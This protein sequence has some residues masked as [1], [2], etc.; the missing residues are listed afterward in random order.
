MPKI[1]LAAARWDTLLAQLRAIA[2]EMFDSQNSSL[3]NHIAGAWKLSGK[4]R[5]VVSPVDGTVLGQLPMLNAEEGKQAVRAAAAEFSA[6]RS[7]PLEERRQAVSQTVDAFQKHRDLFAYLLAWE[8]G[9]PV[10]QSRVSVDR[11][12]EGGRWYVEHIGDMLGQRP[13]LGLISNIA[14]WNYPMSVLMHA[15]LVQALCGNAVIAKVPS[16]GSLYTLSLA[17]ALARKQG[18]PF[19]LI[20]GPGG[21]LSE[22]LIESPEI[23][24]LSY[25]GGKSH[26]RSIARELLE[27]NTRHM[28]EMEGVNAYGIWEFSNW[29][30]LAKQIKKG[31]EYGKQRCTAYPR[32]VVQRKL[33]PQFMSTYLSIVQSLQVGHPL[34]VEE[35][36]TE[37]PAVDFGPLINADKV[38]ELKGHIGDAVFKGAVQLYQADL[39]EQLFLPDQDR[40]AYFA[41][42]ALFNLPQGAH[43]YFNEPFG[44]VDTFVVVDTQEQ[45][46]NEMNISNGNLVS[47]IATDDPE[48]ARQ[49]LPE[50][51][52][53][54][55]GHNKL[56]SRGDKEEPFGGLGQSWKGAYVGGRYLVQAL[57]QPG[58]EQRLYG[59]FPDHVL[60]PEERNASAFD[61]AVASAPKVEGRG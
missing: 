20:S 18:L 14:S 31:Y 35:G 54:K 43:L 24:A 42:T 22:A 40:S 49:V 33:F 16:D 23:A 25:V 26:S 4:S 38:E 5:P 27:H 21:E 47:S 7:K 36:A 61:P 52:A 30:E 8:I 17:V 2:P 55:Y 45:L 57:T 41:P 32:W 58:E 19:T 13:P 12:I 50:L 1:V 39:N 34:L 28:L 59:N 46:I 3:L 60:L 6:W 53:F 10:A 48:I 37:A 44:P 15:M 51:R 11:C 56:R 9:K 29:A